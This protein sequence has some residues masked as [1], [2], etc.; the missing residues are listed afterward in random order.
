MFRT[1]R[2]FALILA[3]SITLA[4]GA[5]AEADDPVVVRVGNFTYTRSQLQR[6]LDST[7]VLSEMLQGD[8]PTDAEKAAQLE[9]VVDSFV[10][11]GVIENKLTEAGSSD[12]R[13]SVSR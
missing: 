5:F 3:L 10:R 6:S 4:F 9:A 8:T 11:L 2:I 13:C 7:L 12:N 1:R